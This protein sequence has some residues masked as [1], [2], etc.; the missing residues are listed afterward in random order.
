MHTFK[1]LLYRGPHIDVLQNDFAKKGVIDTHAPVQ[2]ASEI[3][4]KAPVEVVWEVMAD[5]AHWNDWLPHVTVS[6]FESLAPDSVFAWKNGVANIVSRFAVTERNKELTWTGVSS[7]ANAVDRHTV[8]P[9]Q[10][11]FTRVYTEESMAGPLLVLF[12][13]SKKLKAG[14]EAWLAALKTAAEAKNS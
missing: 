3:I 14:Q 12:F 9:T 10:E 13:S 11:G 6:K 4:V 7:G 2:A 1:A 5:V 8:E